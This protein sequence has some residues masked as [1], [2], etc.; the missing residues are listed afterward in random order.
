[1]HACKYAFIVLHAGVTTSARLGDLVAGLCAWDDIP[2]PLVAVSSPGLPMW[3]YDG[4]A[5]ALT[6]DMD[7][8]CRHFSP[9]SIQKLGKKND[10]GYGPHITAS[11]AQATAVATL[12]AGFAPHFVPALT[13]PTP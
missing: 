2:G 1:M 12:K 9:S 8:K 10:T 11:G 6:G 7:E 3:P 5:H 13:G 4:H